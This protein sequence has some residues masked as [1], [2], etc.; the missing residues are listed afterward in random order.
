M[1]FQWHKKTLFFKLNPSTNLSKMSWFDLFA[2]FFF[3]RI[4]F[5]DYFNNLNVRFS[6][7]SSYAF[8]HTSVD[9]PKSGFWS[10]NYPYLSTAKAICSYIID[11]LVYWPDRAAWDTQQANKGRLLYSSLSRVRPLSHYPGTRSHLVPE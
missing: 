4:I 5:Q 7:E 3:P 11:I 2:S 9:I 8:F 10:S 6:L 1:I